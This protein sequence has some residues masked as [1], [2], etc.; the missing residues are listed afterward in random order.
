MARTKTTRPK[1][2][3]P[4]HGAPSG[5]PASGMPAGGSMAPGAGYKPPRAF[6]STY[7]PEVRLLP[8]AERTARDAERAEQME[9]E[10][11]R[12]AMESEYDA[13]RVRA[14]EALLNRIEGL[15][16]ARQQTLGA[17]RQPVDPARP[18]FIVQIEG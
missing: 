9:A 18:V 15:P 10:L 2:G 3:G 11:F 5:I 12:L 7:Q 6:S 8:P 13:V 17:D 4:G 1:G 16:V 14:S